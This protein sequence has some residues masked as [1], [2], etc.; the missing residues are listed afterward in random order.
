MTGL[1]GF[2]FGVDR[3][4]QQ[5][6]AD[7]GVRR[8]T[9]CTSPSTN[10]HTVKLGVAALRG[11]TLLTQLG[12]RCLEQRLLVTAVHH[13]TDIAVLN[14]REMPHRFVAASHFMTIDAQLLQGDPK[15]ESTVGSMGGVAR[16]AGIVQ[17]VLIGPVESETCSGM[18][19][20]TKLRL[21]PMQPQG[22]DQTVRSMARLTFTVADRWVDILHTLGNLFVTPS[23]T[24]CAG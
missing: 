18:A 24:P 6:A 4:A 16:G 13:V 23:A 10:R 5:P 3:G 12:L 2:E 15:T 8:V 20:E 1:A 19:A 9:R 17:R 22:P 7:S 14:L 21:G 11:M